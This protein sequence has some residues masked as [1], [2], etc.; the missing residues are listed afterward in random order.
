MSALLD[1]LTGGFSPEAVKA[2]NAGS[3]R[4]SHVTDLLPMNILR[5]IFTHFPEL[6]SPFILKIKPV[7]AYPFVSEGC[8]RLDFDDGDVLVEGSAHRSPPSFW[9]K[10]L[11]ADESKEQRGQ[12]V[13]ALLV[14]LKGIVGPGSKLLGAIVE[15]SST[16]KDT[17]AYSTFKSDIVEAM[18]EFK[19][20]KFARAMFL[21]DLAL[22]I[23]YAA[24]FTASVVLDH[25]H[26]KEAVR[27]GALVAAIATA[28][29]WVR[30]LHHEVATTSIDADAA[31]SVKGLL[32]AMFGESVW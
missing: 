29:L 2:P 15:A 9:Q 28:V 19:W 5:D 8:N 14:P 32:G 20:N 3:Q 11:Y 26:E 17:V 16:A 25:D 13:E 12:P 7:R 10:R 18:I 6:A 22:S 27:V 4:G 23:V 30:F 24:A 21:R 31:A 1:I